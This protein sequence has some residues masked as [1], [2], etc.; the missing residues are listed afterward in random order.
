MYSGN[1]SGPV[2]IRLPIEIHSLG[3]I[4]PLSSGRLKVG[5]NGFIKGKKRGQI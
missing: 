5:Q 4:V 2:L 3:G 1:K